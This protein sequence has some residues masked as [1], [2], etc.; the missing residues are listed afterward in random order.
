MLKEQTVRD[1]GLRRGRAFLR[2][3]GLLIALVV[4]VVLLTIGDS[5][6]LSPTNLTN[7]LGQWAP[8]GI[9]AVAETYVIIGRGFDLSVASG[10]SLCAIVAAATAAAGYDVGIAFSAAIA[11]GLAIGFFNALLVCGLS[12]NPFIATVGSGFIILGLDIIATPN[13]YI[14]VEQPG[15]DFVGSGDWYGLPIKGIALICF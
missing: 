1:R 8:A 9:M 2:S 3:N 10:F 7:V 11:A 12:I 14:T 5:A 6:F 15:F 4:L 13:A